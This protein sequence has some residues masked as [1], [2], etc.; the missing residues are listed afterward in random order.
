MPCRGPTGRPTRTTEHTTGGG[1]DEQQPYPE[2]TTEIMP[3]LCDVCAHPR[4]DRHKTRCT[5]GLTELLVTIDERWPELRLTPQ[6][7]ALGDGGAHEFESRP[8]I[9]LTARAHQDPASSPWKLG[10]DDVDRPTLSVLGTIDYWAEKALAAGGKFDDVGWVV[11]QPWI[12]DMVRDLRILARQLRAATGD[13]EPAP[14]GHC[15]AVR[16]MHPVLHE[17]V[18]C[19]EPLYMPDT[20]PRGDDEPVRNVPEIRCPEPLCGRTYTGAE[21]IRIKLAEDRPEREH[22]DLASAKQGVPQRLGPSFEPDWGWLTTQ[23]Y[24]QLRAQHEATRS[25]ARL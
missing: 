13:P 22:S 15:L 11:F 8:P 14:I 20:E 21:L 23:K 3:E 19:G 16:G 6:R 10:P 7:L 4:P 5:I 1:G 12:S 25:A 18:Y 24:E 2:G 9:N 17:L